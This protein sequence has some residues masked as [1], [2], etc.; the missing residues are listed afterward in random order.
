MKVHI[1]ES[2]RIEILNP[3]ALELL[4]NMA[5]EDLIR[6]NSEKKIE[7]FALIEEIRSKSKAEMDIDDIS[8]LVDSVRKSRYVS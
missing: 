3:K 7:L 8:A 6:F 5:D 4:K 2:M 1:M